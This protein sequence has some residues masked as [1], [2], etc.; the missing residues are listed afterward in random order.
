MDNRT[1]VITLALVSTV[2]R[3]GLV[4]SDTQDNFED[5][6]P[7]DLSFHATSFDFAF[8]DINGDGCLDLFAGLCTG[9]KV[10]INRKTDCG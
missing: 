9:Y 1:A 8:I 4:H 10:F 3:P 5:P 6:F 7:S 2:L